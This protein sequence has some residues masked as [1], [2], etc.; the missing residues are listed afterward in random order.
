MLLTQE[1]EPLPTATSAKGPSLDRV[2]TGLF[3]KRVLF[4]AIQ[5]QSLG[6][7][8]CFGGGPELFRTDQTILQTGAL[9]D[10]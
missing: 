10:N 9:S 5:V 1:F 3:G 2:F 7:M 4:I 8:A 6:F